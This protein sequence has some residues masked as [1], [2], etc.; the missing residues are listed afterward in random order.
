MLSS[1]FVEIEA[2]GGRGER[3]RSQE[4]RAAAGQRPG[5][6]AT[7]ARARSLALIPWVISSRDLCSRNLAGVRSEPYKTLESLCLRMSEVIS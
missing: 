1:I 3:G 2:F 7:S 6:A 4:A 5:I